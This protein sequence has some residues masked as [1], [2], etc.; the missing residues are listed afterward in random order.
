MNKLISAIIPSIEEHCADVGIKAK[1][2]NK[3]VNAMIDFSVEKRSE[4][5]LEKLFEKEYYR[6]ERFEDKAKTNIIGVT[7]SVSLILGSYT[8]LT[9]I[10]NKYESGSMLGV[11]SALVFTLSVVYMISAG[12]HATHVIIGENEVYQVN[13]TEASSKN[14]A[15]FL[16]IGL[17]RLKNLIRNNHVYVSYICIR[18]SLIC[19]FFVM[20]I[21]IF[22]YQK[23][24]QTL[25]SVVRNSEK[26]FFFNEDSIEGLSKGISINYVEELVL[27]RV[28]T[29]MVNDSMT[30]V[31]DKERVVVK[32]I[33]E[34]EKVYVEFVDRYQ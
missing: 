30:I 10:Y 8:L 7:I 12:I 13:E 22:P 11:I 20:L 16:S 25:I 33:I 21:A 31:D 5:E 29:S 28:N 4:I 17:N 24:K 19:L 3:D 18:N 6:K 34:N 27:D 23:D 2:K 15:Y 26:Q 9:N 32:F 1:I 14:D